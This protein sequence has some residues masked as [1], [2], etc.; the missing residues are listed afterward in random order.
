MHF[1]TNINF[2][3]LSF[4]VSESLKAALSNELKESIHTGELGIFFILYTYNHINGEKNR[5]HFL[6]QYCIVRNTCMLIFQL[7]WLS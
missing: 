5:R 6:Q 3:D 1:S 2:N 7:A 4:G